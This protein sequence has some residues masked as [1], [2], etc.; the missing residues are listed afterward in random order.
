MELW[1]EPDASVAHGKFY[2]LVAYCALRFQHARCF[3]AR[4]FSKLR[5]RVLQARILL[6]P[7]TPLLL[8]YRA[9]QA[10]FS[11]RKRRWE[12]LVC[13][14]LLL[15]LHAV[16]VVGELSGYLFGPGGSCSQTD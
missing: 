8:L 12:F 4:R 15:L 11:K 2:G 7:L 10:V 3:A 1:L 16:W 5:F 9:G 14:P 13:S 6:S